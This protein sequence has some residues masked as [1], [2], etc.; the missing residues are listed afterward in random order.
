VTVRKRV[1]VSGRVQGVFFRETCRRRA[2]Q[3]GVSGWVANAPSGD[4]EACFEGDAAAVDRMIEWC[5]QGPPQ[6]EVRSVTVDEE[7]PEGASGFSV[8]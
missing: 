6:A 3:E 1:M 8:R 2:E 5:R 4:V 7:P